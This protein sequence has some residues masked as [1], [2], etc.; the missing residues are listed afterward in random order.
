MEILQQLF[1]WATIS[2]LKKRIFSEETM[3]LREY[4]NSDNWFICGV[5]LQGIRGE[6]NVE[7]L[8]NSSIICT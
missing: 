7:T 5:T 1:E 2:K 3:Y 4:V 8:L 6:Y